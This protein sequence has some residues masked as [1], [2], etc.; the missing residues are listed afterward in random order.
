MNEKQ[1]IQSIFSNY[2]TQARRDYRVRLNAS[3]DCV[4]FL[5]RQGLAFRGNNEYE[6]SSNRGNFLELYRFL[7]SHN[8]DIKNVALENAPEN[9]SLTAPKI[10]KDIVNVF[11]VE[12]TNAI[13]R[14]MDDALFSVLIDESRDVS[15]KE[16]MI[17]VFRYVDKN[18]NVVERFIGIK[19]L[20]STT[21]MS[22]KQTLDKLFSRHGLSMFRL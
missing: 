16:Q 3:I 6:E 10:Q 11:A 1:H 21:T 20:A 4:R 19:H 7:V 15:I 18:E 2:S 9:H 5:L 14:E 22:L 8:E 12:T 13:I 17:V